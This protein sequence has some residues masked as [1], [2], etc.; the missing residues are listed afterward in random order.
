MRKRAQVLTESATLLLRVGHITLWMV[1]WATASGAQPLERVSEPTKLVHVLPQLFGSDG[2]FVDSQNHRAHFNASF[3]TGFEP[4]NRAFASQLATTLVPPPITVGGYGFDRSGL[5][6]YSQQHFGV[7]LS[8][9]P[10][11]IGA[12]QFG[13]GFSVQHANFDSLDGVRLNTMDTAFTHDSPEL[14]GVRSDVVSARNVIQARQT[15]IVGFLSYGVSDWLDASLIVPVVTTRL[16]ATSL[17]TV[18]RLGS[19]ANPGT[20]FFEEQDDPL[21]TTRLFRA[22]GQATGLGD[23]S[24]RLKAL[25]AN[26]GVSNV[27]LGV[28]VR[29]PTGD[30][31]NLLGTGATGIRPFVTWSLGNQRVSPHA[32]LAYQ[33]NGPSVLAAPLGSGTTGDLADELGYSVGAAL[34]LGEHANVT[35]DVLGR[36][37]F[38][39]LRLTRTDLQSANGIVFPTVRF[40]A[41]SRHRIHAAIGLFSNGY[42]GLRAHVT[43]LLQ[44]NEAGLRDTLIPAGGLQLGF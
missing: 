21:G 27:A 17:A 25:V 37:A 2:L 33:W 14:G 19:A 11:V 4:M 9:R 22:R 6:R 31:E 42:R 44:L 3:E 30:A 35:V 7:A 36:L 24:A 34:A 15:Q 41:A 10:E 40:D 38:D 20:H 13:L 5:F 29:L 28:D 18:H 32:S 26:Q 1:A 23:V 12:G 43:L 39:A 16:D 8:E